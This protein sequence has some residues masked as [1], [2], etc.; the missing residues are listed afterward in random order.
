MT[1]YNSNC[2]KLLG[3]YTDSKLTSEPHVKSFRKKANQK[4]NAFARTAYKSH[5]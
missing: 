2:Q 4:Q 3:I 1:I 5:S